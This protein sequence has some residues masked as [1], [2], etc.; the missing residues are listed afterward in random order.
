MNLAI[1]RV[2]RWNPDLDP[3]EDDMEF[4]LTYAGA[5]YAHQDS[6][7]LQ[8]RSDHVHDIRRK[9]HEQLKVLWDNHPILLGLRN[10]PPDYHLPPH[11]PVMQFF[12]HDGFNWLPIVNSGNGL[13][14]KLDILMLR[15]GPPGTV[16]T[17]ID[18]RIKTIF[19]ALRKASGPAEL[20]GKSGALTPSSQEEPFY[21]LLED[22]KLI[23]H[24]S[25]TSDTL[26]EPVNDPP[27]VPPDNAVRLVISVTVKPYSPFRETV[28][29]A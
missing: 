15:K 20:C 4:R 25:V 5:L 10:A 3:D 11:P 13:I 17:D 14:C 24:A 9:F 2:L 6:R 18:N 22:D 21:V 7:R 16:P 8:N 26:L 23:T 27:N 1:R 29:Y 12:K 19:D 28:G